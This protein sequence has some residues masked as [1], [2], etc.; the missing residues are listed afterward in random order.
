MRWRGQELV[1]SRGKFIQLSG[2]GAER[3]LANGPFV[4]GNLQDIR[5]GRV[6][7]SK[8]LSR[9]PSAGLEILK[10]ERIFAETPSLGALD[11][12]SR[13]PRAA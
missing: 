3:I 2:A 11:V 12:D 13:N 10:I 5:P 4:V 8:G 6:T 9:N 1:T 7:G